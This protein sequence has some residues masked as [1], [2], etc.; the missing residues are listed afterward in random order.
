MYAIVE[1]GSRQ[2]RV[3]PG[4]KFLVEKLAHPAGSSIELPVLL[5]SDD[6]GVTV[7]TPH[8]EGKTLT[9]QV[10]GEVKGE[11]LIAFKYTPKK[12]YR[13]K[14]GHRQ[15]YTLL[16]VPPEKGAEVPQAEA[17]SLT[18]PVEAAQSTV[19][20]AAA[21][22]AEVDSVK[23][24]STDEVTASSTP[25]ADNSAPSAPAADTAAAELPAP[26]DPTA[27]ASDTPGDK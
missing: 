15:T 3:S 26:S 8:V 11:K 21:S 18:Q 1:V 5:L 7:G 17:A 14:T 25:N 22:V 16:Q 2:Y 4:E 10:M 24:T 12:R 20:P 27:K 13:R 19:E 23:A 6:S 9:V